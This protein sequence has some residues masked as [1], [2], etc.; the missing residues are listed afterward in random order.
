MLTTGG[1][2]ASADFIIGGLHPGQA[3]PA[4]L[5]VWQTTETAYFVRMPDVAVS[6]T[7]GSFTVPLSANAMISVTTTTGQGTPSPVHPI[8]ASAPF[9]FPWADDF[10]AYAEGAYA[11]YFCD[12]GGVFVVQVRAPGG[13][14]LLELT[15]WF[16]GGVHN[17]ASLLPPQP[18]PRG[19]GSG[20]LA[21]TNIITQ[22]PI[23]WETNPTPTSMWVRWGRRARRRL[24]SALRAICPR[25][26]QDRKLQRC[27]GR[28]KLD[29]LCRVSCGGV[30]P[31]SAHAP[32]SFRRPH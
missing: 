23:A 27:P 14:G 24:Q 8:P 9:P 19:V 28:A 18:L 32:S 6:A 16:K 10:E 7:D 25:C 2:A 26:L 20:G 12:E 11:K 15:T 4:V 5:H 1:A 21:L 17:P 22:V 30:R 13:L 3:L 31:P 29:R